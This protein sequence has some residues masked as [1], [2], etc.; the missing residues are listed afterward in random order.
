L[1]KRLLDK[2]KALRRLFKRS[3]DEVQ[4]ALVSRP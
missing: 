3:L 2:T 4:E 1:F